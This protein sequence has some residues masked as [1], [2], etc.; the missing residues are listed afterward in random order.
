[1][2]VTISGPIQPHSMRHSPAQWPEPHPVKPSCRS[3]RKARCGSGPAVLP[4]PLFARPESVPLHNQRSA[5]APRRRRPRRPRPGPTQ[6]AV[7]WAGM[8][9]DRGY[10]LVDDYPPPSYACMSWPLRHT[11]ISSPQS[12]LRVGLSGPAKDRFRVWRRNSFTF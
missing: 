1:M 6:D 2:P 10:C 5:L 9:A 7:S 4:T 3:R 8:W 11:H 12:H